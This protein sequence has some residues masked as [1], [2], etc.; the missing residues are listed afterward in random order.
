MEKNV[1][2]EKDL[3]VIIDSQLQFDEHIA[4]KVKK[5]N[6]MVGL[7]RWSISYLDGHLFKNL[8]IMFV[9]SHLEHTQSVWSPHL[10]KYIYALENVKARASKLV[11]GFKGMEYEDRK[12]DLPTLAYR[13]M[14][15]DLI[16]VYKHFN[17]Y[18]KATIPPTFQTCE[19]STQ[20]HSQQLLSRG[21]KEGVC[22]LHTNF[23]IKG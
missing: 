10:R 21:P 1:F 2:E 17:A 19:T 5:P 18:D 7:I 22:G 14:R 3:G 4:E 9:R 15:G 11:D 12:L 16:E 23:F 6:I 8:F 13:R 20:G